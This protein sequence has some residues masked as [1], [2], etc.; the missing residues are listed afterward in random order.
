LQNYRNFAIQNK[1][2][3]LTHDIPISIASHVS[4]KRGHPYAPPK[5]VKGDRYFDLAEAKGLDL[6]KGYFSVIADTYVLLYTKME[7]LARLGN[8]PVGFVNRTTWAAQ[9]SPAKPLV[10]LSRDQWDDNQL[11]PL[12]PIS[13]DDSKVTWVDI[14]VNNLD[15]KG[16]PFHLV[17]ISEA[18]IEIPMLNIRY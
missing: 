17:C 8:V 2:L 12:I 4:T 15:E 7:I 11:V 18:D 14:V 13:R 5:I 16:H 3:T 1:A 10:D 9:S 6:P